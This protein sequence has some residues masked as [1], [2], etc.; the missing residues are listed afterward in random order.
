MQQSLHVRFIFQ[1]SIPLHG[2]F[3]GAYSFNIASD[4]IGIIVKNQ[5]SLDEWYYQVQL[6][7]C[8]GDT[9]LDATKGLTW[10]KRNLYV[11]QTKENTQIEGLVLRLKIIH[12][13]FDFRKVKRRAIRFNV[14]CFQAGAFIGR[15]ASEICQLLPKKRTAG[16][17]DVNGEGNF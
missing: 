8:D 11:L 17:S 3:Q 4:G 14:N 13:T 12:G 16:D 7:S 5:S 2:D 9:E 15:G 10:P 1:L 6:L